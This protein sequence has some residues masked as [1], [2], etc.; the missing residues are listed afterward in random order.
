MLYDVCWSRYCLWWLAYGQLPWKEGDALHDIVDRKLAYKEKGEHAC[1]RPV[2]H[3]LDISH[4]LEFRQQPGASTV[5]YIR[6]LMMG[7]I[8]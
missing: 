5:Q 3:M 4:G 7:V 1:P 8:C 6:R 2:V